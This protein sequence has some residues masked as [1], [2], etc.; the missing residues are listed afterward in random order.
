MTAGTPAPPLRFEASVNLHSRLRHF[1]CRNGGSLASLAKAAPCLSQD[2]PPSVN[3]RSK[4]STLYSIRRTI[5]P[6][7][8]ENIGSRLSES[9]SN[10]CSP[11]MAALLDALGVRRQGL[12]ARLSAQ[13]TS[14]MLRGGRGGQVIMC[15]V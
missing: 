12:V 6:K 7:L 3:T 5:R 13:L 14:W 4:S 1:S 11:N 15:P 9:S 10:G 2:S 8:L